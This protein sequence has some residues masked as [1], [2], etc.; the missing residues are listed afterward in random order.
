MQ[1]II[2]TPPIPYKCENFNMTYENQQHFEIVGKTFP[3][4]DPKP[5]KWVQQYQITMKNNDESHDDEL[6]Y[7]EGQGSA[8]DGPKAQFREVIYSYF[9]ILSF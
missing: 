7:Y 5:E 3:V 4:P 6:V 1:N 9:F 2:Q 8:D